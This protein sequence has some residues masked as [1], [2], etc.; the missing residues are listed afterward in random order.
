MVSNE[1]DLKV[2]YSSIDLGP[3]EGFD[4][5]RVAREGADLT[6]IASGPC[7]GCHAS[8]Q[9]GVGLIGS[10][11]V[12]WVKAEMTCECGST[13]GEEDRTGCGRTWTVEGVAG[14]WI[15]SKE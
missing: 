8:G 2:P 7:P 15:L 3:T 10:G 6:F 13:H 9:R 11:V 4:R 5:R 14:D 1:H 12:P